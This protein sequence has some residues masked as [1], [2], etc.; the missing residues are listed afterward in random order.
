M[1]IFGVR[2]HHG[3]LTAWWIIILQQIW[4]KVRESIRPKVTILQ[5]NI[6]LPHIWRIYL[7]FYINSILDNIQCLISENPILCLWQGTTYW[8]IPPI[9]TEMDV[10]VLYR[11][12]YH[13]KVH[14]LVIFWLLSFL[15][16][17]LIESYIFSLLT[18]WW[19]KRFKKTQFILHVEYFII[20]FW[21]SIPN[22][23]WRL[24]LAFPSAE[25][26]RWSILLSNLR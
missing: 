11:I 8:N 4:V 22:H 6:K 19:N 26:G 3:I 21:V 9:A 10:L 13:T 14:N 20:S 1:C 18:P 7:F 5:I 15:Y 17:L 24:H 12:L 16:L 23:P 2:V 25:S